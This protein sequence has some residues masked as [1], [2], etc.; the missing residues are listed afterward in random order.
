MIEDSGTKQQKCCSVKFL[1]KKWKT[2]NFNM[3]L[4]IPTLKEDFKR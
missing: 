2:A 4:T 1:G 3:S